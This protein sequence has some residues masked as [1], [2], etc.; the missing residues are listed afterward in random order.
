MQYLTIRIFQRTLLA[1]SLAFFQ[2]GMVLQV[3]AVLAWVVF[4]IILGAA[5]AA[6]G[7]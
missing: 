4:V 2:L 1:Y 6:A 7:R 3:L 5:G